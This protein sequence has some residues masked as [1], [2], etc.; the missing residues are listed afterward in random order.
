MRN[1]SSLLVL[2]SITCGCAGTGEETDRELLESQAVRTLV[3]DAEQ[4][5]SGDQLDQAVEL[6]EKA[7]EIDPTHF[8]AHRLLQE[9]RILRGQEDEVI[10]GARQRVHDRPGDAGA[11]VLLARVLDDPE[12]IE[13]HL[14]LALEADAGFAW[15]HVGK[16]VE[17]ARRGEFA[18]AQ[19]HLSRAVERDVNLSEA[20][21][22]RANVRD[23][24]ADFE[25][26]ADDYRTYLRF[27]GGDLGA[28]YKLASITHRELH[29]PDEAEELYRVLLDLDDGMTSAVVG[30]AVC[31]TEQR[32]FDAARQL[33]ERVEDLEPSAL[34]NL[35]MLYQDHL[36][37]PDLARQK[38]EKF[39][40]LE[41]EMASR[42]SIADRYIYAPVRLS[43]LDRMRAREELRSGEQR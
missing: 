33:Y 15:A 5:L 18:V 24:L 23:Q 25:G 27:R 4:R 12:A 9:A 36:D 41:G 26:A 38:F 22:Y 16:G 37:Q 39:M 1:L 40:Q 2:L 20:Y 29:R 14:D 11:Q 21:L 34:F 35:G 19:Q 8:R 13:R 32:R 10:A 30:L 3:V 6:L 42:R 31:L 43:E 28:L 17:A 7:L